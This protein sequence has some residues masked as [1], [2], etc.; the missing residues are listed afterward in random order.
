M[1]RR[2]RFPTGLGYVLPLLLMM[3]I[4]FDLPLMVMLGR[5]ISAPF[6]T[7]RHYTYLIEQPV[8]LE[9]LAN[10]FRIA[11]VVTIGAVIIGYPLAY[12][13]T[14]ISKRAQML[15]VS[16]VI[17]SFLVSLLIRTYAWIVILG[18]NGIVNRVLLEMGLIGSPLQFIYNDL[19]VTIGTLNVL[20]PFMIIPLYTSMLKMD[21]RLLDA[22]ASLGADPVRTFIRVYF[23]LTLPSLLSCAI[24][25]FILTLGFFITPAILGGGNVAMIATVLDTLINQL[26]EWE[27]AAALSV[28]LLIVTLVCYAG[29][30]KLEVMFK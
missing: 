3:I 18:N 25:V 16:V 21:V 5:S 6:P 13:M 22:A 11:I 20:L 29:Y 8:Y 24:L 2:K 26:A 17:L 9:V 15:A 1:P 7:F 14:R 27:L 19:G 4:V 10:T 30:R 23:P 12:W 28:I